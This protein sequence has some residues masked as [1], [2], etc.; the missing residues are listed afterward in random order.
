MWMLE[1]VS[2][3]SKVWE[4]HNVQSV[5]LMTET[6]FQWWPKRMGYTLD[7]FIWLLHGLITVVGASIVDAMSTMK[8]MGLDDL[9][10][11][12]VN[13]VSTIDFS[14]SKTASTVSVFES[15]I[16]YVGGLLSAFELNGNQPQILVQKA[17]QLADKLAIGFTSSP[18]PIPFGFIDFSSNQPVIDT[19]SQMTPQHIVIAKIDIPYSSRTSQKQAQ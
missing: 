17:Q 8:I 12:A 19:V 6:E 9:F 1:V 10:Q 4:R 14:Q 11:N 13:F 15:S 3:V 7:T 16:R 2:A 5:Y 18:S